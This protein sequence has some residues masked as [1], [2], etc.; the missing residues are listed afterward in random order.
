MGLTSVPP[1]VD[2]TVWNEVDAL[3]DA[4]RAKNARTGKKP[5]HLFT[6]FV[7][8]L[9]AGEDVCAVEFA[10]VHLRTRGRNKIGIR[11]SKPSS[12]NN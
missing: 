12:T 1:I 5:V 6:G 10:E 8:L 11:I 9:T 7:V 3:L 2:E 4:G